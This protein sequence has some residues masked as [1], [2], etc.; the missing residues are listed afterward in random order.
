MNTQNKLAPKS[1]NGSAGTRTLKQSAEMDNLLS[2]ARSPAKLRMERKLS[3]MS[4]MGA[5]RI[6]KMTIPS[7]TLFAATH[8]WDRSLDGWH[9]VVESPAC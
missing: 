5:T 8:S 3:G 9:L 7:V 2:I 4:S 1:A 6:T